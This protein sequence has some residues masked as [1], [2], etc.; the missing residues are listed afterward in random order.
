MAA[1]TL[2]LEYLSG[3]LETESVKR[4]T[5]DIGGPE[6]L[7]YRDL[8]A[9]FAEEAGLPRRRI[10]GVPVLTPTLS[11]YWIHLV[12]P[13]PAAIANAVFDATSIRLRH[14]PFSPERVK[15]ALQL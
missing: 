12:T 14:N 10:I 15:A 6:V 2:V 4:Q 13:V 3:C 5:F 11:A 8:I 9:I 7:S 1:R